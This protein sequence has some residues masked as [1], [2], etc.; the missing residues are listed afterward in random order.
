[1]TTT[2]NHMPEWSVYVAIALTI[3]ITWIYMCRNQWYREKGD[4]H[5][6]RSS[7]VP[8]GRN[9]WPLIGE[10]VEYIASAYAS[11]PTSF[12]DKRKAL[13]GDVFRTHLLGK[14]VIASTDPD[15][16]KVI[17][18]NHDNTFIPSYPK[19][20]TEL[21]G[22]TSILRMDGALHKKVHATLARFLKSPHLKS[23][24]TRDIEASVKLSLAGWSTDRLIYVQDETK[25][26]TF[27]I[28]VT[29]LMSVG[30]G[31][32]LELLKRE[33]TEFIKGLICLPIKLPGTQL[34]KSLK[35]KGRLMALTRRIVEERKRTMDLDNAEDKNDSG[36][37]PAYN[38]AIDALLG[39]CG[40]QVREN[41]RLS[42]DFICGNIV[43]M[44]I[45]GEDSVPKAITLAVKFLSDNPPAL[46]QLKE[47]CM[48]LKRQKV[49]ANVS[50]TWNDY[51]SLSFTQNVIS[52]TL[53]MANIVNALWRQA[54]QDVEI[55]G[56]LIQEGWG[57]M[58][59]LTSVHMDER[60]YEN[61]YRFDPWRWERKGLSTTSNTFNPFGGGQRLCPGLDLSRL[62]ISIFLHHLV[63][64]YRW[65]AEKD[66][67]IYF[68]TVKM[69]RKLPISVSPLT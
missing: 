63:T 3:A 25:K 10:T 58:A 33:Y 27:E 16:N 56:H 22:E 21:F 65:V 44:M 62:E 13:Y 55:K 11:R 39:D 17:M 52:E 42:S 8:R 68:P 32:D 43:E 34:Y 38:D 6:L 37:A 19:S 5:G 30:P 60:I 12:M 41:Q 20:I 7:K 15:V 47:E 59:S 18:N 48:E 51:M 61:P 64:T 57:V 45:P 67:V 14:P 1:M 69:K 29:A 28:L 2:E 23:R 26:I 31:E 24:I 40:D 9:G 49:K 50:Y 66:E 53:R 54:T 4:S 46:E 36:A 35:A